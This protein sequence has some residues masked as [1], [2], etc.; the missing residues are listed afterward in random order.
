MNIIGKSTAILFISLGGILLSACTLPGM[1]PVAQVDKKQFLSE[2]AQS[3]TVVK[4][5]ECSI[6]EYQCKN[7]KTV[8]IQPDNTKKAIH[9]TFAQTTHTLSSVVTKKSQKYS[10]IRWV[11]SEDFSGKWKLRDNRNKVLAENCVKKESSQ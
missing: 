10:N 9:L 3:N 5:K 2:S 6:T 4:V 1:S 8:T 11:W 7:N